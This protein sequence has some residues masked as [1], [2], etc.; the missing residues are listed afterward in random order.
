MEHR[1]CCNPQRT[2][3]RWEHHK[4]QERARTAWRERAQEVSPAVERVL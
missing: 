4:E 2:P 1:S 3:E